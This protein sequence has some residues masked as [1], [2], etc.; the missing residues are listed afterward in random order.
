MT[1]GE[2]GKFIADGAKNSG[3]K[4]IFVTTTHEDAAK[5]I[6]EIMQKDDVIL[7]KASHGMHFEKIIE[8]I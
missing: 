6:L 8:L 3:L 4:N 2:L 5:K 7:F 1:Y